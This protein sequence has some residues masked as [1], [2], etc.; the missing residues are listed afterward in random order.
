MDAD[1][2][3]LAGRFAT[4]AAFLE[5]NPG[6]LACG[7]DVGLIDEIG[8]EVSRKGPFLSGSIAMADLLDGNPLFHPT[9]MIRRETMVASGQYRTGCTHA[10]DYDLWLRICERG[11]LANLPDKTLLFRKHGKQISAT[12]RLA[13]RAATALARQVA[14]RRANGL[15][16]GADLSNGLDQ[17]VR[18][19]LQ[20]RTASPAPIRDFEGKDLLVMARFAQQAAGRR[21]I[22]GIESRI[23]RETGL[24]KVW[25]MPLWYFLD[26]TKIRSSMRQRR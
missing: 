25:L 14:L 3:A 16:E 21:W 1:D 2:I 20:A 9:M 6:I 12:K 8:R 19:Y 26:R 22:S 11:P 24:R 23:K 18:H 4:Q 7:T 15:D 10:E 5:G 13:Q 17:V